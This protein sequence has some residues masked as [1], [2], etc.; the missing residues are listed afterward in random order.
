MEMSSFDEKLD[1]EARERCDVVLDGIV[2]CQVRM[3]DNKLINFT[4][5]VIVKLGDK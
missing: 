3:T 4:T 5:N 2:D 1:F